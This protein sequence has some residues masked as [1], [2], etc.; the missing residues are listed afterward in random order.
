[1]KFKVEITVEQQHLGDA[2]AALHAVEVYQL[3]IGPIEEPLQLPAPAAVPAK[4]VTPWTPTQQPKERKKKTMTPA[5]SKVKE[6]AKM[7]AQGDYIPLREHILRHMG[8]R[9]VGSSELMALATSL[10]FKPTGIGPLL[11]KLTIDGVL[12]KSGSIAEGYK[13]QTPLPTRQEE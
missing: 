1:M 10:G 9:A 3:D 8:N 4:A 5:T 6:A 13:W 12:V 11:S 2:L 7:R